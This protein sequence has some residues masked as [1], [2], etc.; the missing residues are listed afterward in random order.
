MSRLAAQTSLLRDRGEGQSRVTN[1]ELFFDLVFVFA[2]TQLSHFLFGHLSLA[3]A[4]QTALLFIAVWWVWIFTTWF[5]N[6]LDPD[7]APV[8]LVMFVLMLAGLVLSACLPAAFA[9]RGLAFAAVYVFMQVGR[10]AF[11]VWA[12]RRHNPVNFRN[13][14][15]ITVWLLVS[16]VFWLLG[17]IEHDATRFAL[18]V[19]ALALE[20][21]APSL[22][23]AVPGL[24]HSTTAD[25]DV[26]GGH[27]AERCSQFVLIA[28]GESITVT[29][30]AFFKLSWSLEIVTAFVA[31]FVGSVALWWIYFD[32]GAG[33]GSHMIE[34]SND[35]GR[36]ARLAYT[37]IH[38]AL[39][40]GIIISAVA[41]EL[42]LAHPDAMAG[43][44]RHLV[45]FIGPALYL[46]GNIGFKIATGAKHYP[47]SHLIGL[48]LLLVLGLTASGL[49]LLTLGVA[50]TIILVIVACWE[51]IALRSAS[52]QL[53]TKA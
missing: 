34:Q 13:F 41:D 12:L 30:A 50:T 42:T 43:T 24:G 6:W 14:R 49:S 9:R 21:I 4:A 38:A 28:L 5:T 31:A 53:V 15:R 17:G 10:S 18:W 19:V 48:A 39:I 35:P 45:L 26:D 7:R 52:R 11:M 22:G 1:I 25:W 27:L 3:G 40:A 2:I 44:A 23:F 20:L 36:L 8:R 29:G 47:L 46:L 51:T 37:Y 33:R 16:G 32:T